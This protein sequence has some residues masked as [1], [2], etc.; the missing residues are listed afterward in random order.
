MKYSKDGLVCFDPV[1][2]TYTH[3]DGRVLEGVTSYIK[4]HTNIFDADLQSK[5][6]AAKHGLEQ[7]EVLAAWK[8][9]AEVSR[10]NGTAVH[11]VLESYCNTGKI[12]VYGICEKEKVAVKFIKDFFQTRLTPIETELIVYN[13]HVASQIDCIARNTQGEYFILDW[14]TNAEIKKDGWGRTML[15]PYNHL[16]DASYYHYSLQLAI[17]KSLCPYEIK[18]SFIVHFLE[19]DYSILSPQLIK[20]IF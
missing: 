12:L 18:D 19:N 11:E 14:K 3:K 6:Y 2:H 17:Y 4:R 8:E 7:S 15:S 10:N 16:P 20:V 5:K 1:K 9:K 13:D